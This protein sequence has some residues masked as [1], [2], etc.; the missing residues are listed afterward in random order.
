M[1]GKT[2]LR[3]LIVSVILYQTLPD[4]SY[5]QNSPFVPN[6]IPDIVVDEDFGSTTVAMLDTVFDDMDLPSDSLRYTVSVASEI[7]TGIIS[8]DSLWLFSVTDSNGLAEVIVTATDD[9]SSSVSDTFKVTITPKGDNPIVVNPIMDVVVDEDFGSIM[10]ASLD[11]VFDDTDLPSDSLRYT[12]SVSSDI[13]TGIIS[14]DSLWLFSVT[15]SNGLAEVIVTATDDSSASVSDTFKVTIIP[16]GDDPS[17]VNPIMDVIVDEDFG[18]IMV[19]SLDTVF[20]DIDLPSDSL[21]YTVSVSSDII[22]G[23]VS[24]GSLWLFSVTDSNGLAEVVVTATD[25]SSVSVSDTFK[26]TIIPVGDFPFGFKLA[27]PLGDTLNTLLPL[28]I[29]HP[30]IDS[31]FGEQTDYI[32]RIS[33]FESLRSPLHT[34]IFADTSYTLTVPLADDFLYF[35]SVTA[36]DSSGRFIFSDT[37]FFL[38]DKQESPLIFSLLAPGDNSPVDLLRQ[39]FSWKQSIDPDPRDDVKYTLIIMSVSDTDSVVYISTGIEDTTHQVT[40]DIENGSYE[41]WVIAEDTDDKSL[42]TQSNEVFRLNVI[43][44]IEAGLASIPEKYNLFQNYPNPFNPVTIIRYSLPKSGD[45]SLIIYNLKGQEI[46]ILVSAEKEAGYHKITFNASGVA[47]GIY[48]Y[49]LQAGDFVRTRKMVL[50]K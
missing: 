43:V 17:V 12:V 23:I 9:S 40:E 16:K 5:A 10:V 18:F 46:A 13:I 41:W 22:T 15:D 44:G 34:G 3:T 19:A 39:V 4:L 31:G 42:N 7:I 25:D 20:D 45:I 27:S 35:W 33:A 11:T 29:W 32:I 48:F 49:R 28:F 50:L 37:S 26:V 30:P 47:S 24:G 36:I 6:P 14:G 38:L 21:R 2:L 8:G 1:L